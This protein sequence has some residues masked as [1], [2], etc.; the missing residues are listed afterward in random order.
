MKHL[1]L[2]SLI[3]VS[4]GSESKP[5]D[6]PSLT[7]NQK[8]EIKTQQKS[9]PKEEQNQDIVSKEPVASEDE[10]DALR[11]EIYYQYHA[12]NRATDFR[13]KIYRFVQEGTHLPFMF[14]I[15]GRDN[16]VLGEI[17]LTGDE[18]FAKDVL[19][20]FVD[21]G[22]VSD[23]TRAVKKTMLLN[24]NYFFYSTTVAY[25]GVKNECKLDNVNL[26]EH[27]RRGYAIPSECIV[28]DG[29]A[30]E[31]I[32]TILLEGKHF[33]VTKVFIGVKL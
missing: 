23:A 13:D 25:L 32:K 30:Y 22:S 20:N 21:T 28:K 15:E 19:K 11:K 26:A 6:V 31:N 1:L 29:E 12:S 27:F 16:G 3:L 4:C 18:S 2:V 33:D 10:L 24:S 17:I 8:E 7:N 9:Q 14:L 5:K